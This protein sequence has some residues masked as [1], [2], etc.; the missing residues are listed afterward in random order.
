MHEKFFAFSTNICIKTKIFKT[1]PLQN[2]FLV[3]F[4]NVFFRNDKNLFSQLH[5]NREVATGALKKCFRNL[6]RT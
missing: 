4:L 5:Y 1:K 2:T 3:I 6:I